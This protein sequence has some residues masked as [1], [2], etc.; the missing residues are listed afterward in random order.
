MLALPA[1]LYGSV[2]AVQSN[3]FNVEIG[4][5]GIT[6]SDFECLKHFETLKENSDKLSCR[7]HDCCKLL[8]LVSH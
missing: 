8:L 1:L 7:C 6:P 2:Q 5:T 3:D 4:F